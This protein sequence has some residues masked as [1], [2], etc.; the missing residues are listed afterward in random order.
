MNNILTID[1]ILNEL[2]PCEDA[3]P[4]LKSQADLQT[5]WDNC[6]R[7]DWMIWLLDKTRLMTEMLDLRI[8]LMVLEMPLED[9]RKVID[10]I[11]DKR[12]L[13]FIDLKRRKLAGEII[14]NNIWDAAEAAAWE[15]AG[16]TRAADWAADWEVAGVTAGD[17]AEAAGA[18]RGAREANAWAANT[19]AWTVAEAVAEAAVW[20]AWAWQANRIREFVP[21][22][23]T[24]GVE[25]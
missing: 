15:V 6:K 3:I 10:L 1:Y 20:T 12:S 7:G 23:S 5:A 14:D 4:Y 21:H 16:A 22:L 24:I 11:T 17:A 8:Q 19:I 13:A 25:S 9:D 18:A 2:E